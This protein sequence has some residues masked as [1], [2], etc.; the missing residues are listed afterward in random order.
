M[1]RIALAILITLAANAQ[2]TLDLAAIQ[3]QAVDADPRI[4]QLELEA[5]QTT[6]RLRN[7]DAERR[8]SLTVEGQVQYQSEVVEF[9]FS[10]P[11]GA[12]PEP[13]PKDTYDAALRVDHSLLDPTKNARRAAE[14]ARLGEAQARIRTALFGLRQEVHEAFFAAALLQERE[15]QIANT[16][17][18]LESRLRDANIRVGE[19][20]ALPSESASIE[21]TLL[22]RRQDAAE[23]RAGRRGALARLAELTNREL[24]LDDRLIIPQLDAQSIEARANLDTLRARPEFAQFARMRERLETQK[25][26]VDA[27]VRPRLSAYGKAGVGKPGLNFLSNE[28]NPYWLAGIR[29]QWKPWTWGT[30]QRERELL[31]LQQQAVTADEEAFARTLRRTLTNDLATIDHLHEVSTTD[32]RIVAL[33]ESIERET[34]A[35][36]DEHVVTAADYID[37]QTDVLEA[38]LLRA[39]HRVQLAQAQARLL[40]LLGLEVR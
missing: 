28:F 29:L 1:R 7:I 10:S 24:T 21:A 11:G 33:R 31:D 22:Q 4:R 35:R 5:A 23:L 12:G 18:D 17:T 30:E 40:T 6:L 39:T 15:A 8:P 3:Q 34:R 2:E 27:S 16:I 20:V 14:Q 26:L 36:Y 19:G 32:D 9:P 38:R 25:Q 13:P 37:K